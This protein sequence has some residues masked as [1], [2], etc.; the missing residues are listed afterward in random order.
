MEE[1]T[2]CFVNAR[3]IP[4][5]LLLQRIHLRFPDTMDRIATTEY[6]QTRNS[7][8]SGFPYVVFYKASSGFERFFHVLEPRIAFQDVCSCW[9]GGCRHH[10]EYVIVSAISFRYNHFKKLI[11]RVILLLNLIP[12]EPYDNVTHCPERSQAIRPT[13]SI[14]GVYHLRHG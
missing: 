7:L 4:L 10:R 8:K 1:F 14:P 5:R 6:P 2:L 13:P 3:S 12:T 11:L 9:S